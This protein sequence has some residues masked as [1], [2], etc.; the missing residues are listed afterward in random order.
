MPQV[1]RVV[2]GKKN[3]GRAN[4]YLDGKFSFA[5][6]L[7]VVVRDGIRRGM[8]LSEET[9]VTYKACDVEE[10]LYGKVLNFL[11]YRPHSVYEVRT[12]IRRYAPDIA[13]EKTNALVDRLKREGY[14]S[15]QEFAQWFAG[16]RASNRPRSRRALFAELAAKGIEKEIIEAVLPRGDQEAIRVAVARHKNLTREKL[17]GYLA[18]QG[19]SYDDVKAALLEE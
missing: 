19:F 1:T 18:R 7:E 14:L 15:D 10:K 9:V 6:S 13:E 2:A 12:R 5:V 8:D 11:S 17:M 4:I 3:P 16:S